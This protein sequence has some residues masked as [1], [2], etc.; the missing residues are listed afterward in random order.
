MDF[1]WCIQVIDFL[2]LQ[3]FFMMCSSCPAGSH[4]CAVLCLSPGQPCSAS[5]WPHTEPISMPSSIPVI[6]EGEWQFSWNHAVWSSALLHKVMLDLIS[7]VVVSLSLC[8]LLFFISL[9]I[10]QLLHFYSVLWKNEGWPAV[11]TLGNWLC[12][13]CYKHFTPYHE[14]SALMPELL[15][16]PRKAGNAESSANCSFI[17]LDLKS[18]KRSHSRYSTCCFLGSAHCHRLSYKFHKWECLYQ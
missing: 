5:A 3:Q 15:L 6:Q 4:T 9:S 8:F 7:F 18:I 12:C 13:L 1:T 17:L 2:L 11:C 10:K 16:L 14:C